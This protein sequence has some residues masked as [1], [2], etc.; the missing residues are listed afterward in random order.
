[1]TQ[2][3]RTSTMFTF[4]SAT[5]ACLFF[6]A[7]CPFAGMCWTIATAVIG[8]CQTLDCTTTKISRVRRG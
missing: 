7:D 2:L 8:V 5:T 4:L 3:E 6:L 1:M